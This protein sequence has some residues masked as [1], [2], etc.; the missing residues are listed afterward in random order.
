MKNQFI[1]STYIPKDKRKKILLLSDDLRMPSGVGTM[2]REI[3][4]NTAQHFNWV[5]IGGAI[6]HPEIGKV[7]DLSPDINN[8][9]GIQDSNVILYPSNGYGDANMVRNIMAFHKIDAILHYTDPRFWIWLYQIEHEIRQQIPILFYHVWDDLPYP[10]Y[11]QWFYESCDWISCISKQTHNIVK[12]VWKKNP[13]KDWQTAYIPHGINPDVF[14]PIEP[15][16]HTEQTKK[17]GEFKSSFF[18]MFPEEPE[19]IVLYNSRNIRRKLA[20]NVLLAFD[21]FCKKLPQEKADKCVLIMHTQPVDENGTD[22]PACVQSLIPNRKV[23]FSAGRIAPEDMNLLYNMSDVTINMSNAE[24]FGL[25]TAESVMAGTPMIATVTGGL[26][27]QMRFEDE[28]GNI[29]EFNS[30]FGSNHT[31]K[32]KKC[33]EWAFPLFPSV[34]SLT[35][36]PMTPYIFEDFAKFE[37]AADRILEVYN[38]PREERRRRGKSGRTWM[39]TEE[40]GMSAYEMANRFI[41]GINTTFQ[42]WTPRKSF[43]IFKI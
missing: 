1:E 3:V 31:G 22:L 26:Q 17:M 8:Y 11:N 37:D 34:R 13:P 6:N 16:I 2:S 40:S 39:L 7:F 15:E 33:G 5:Q 42:N 12:N 14:F 19:F 28:N 35:G 36:S 21:E 27:D 24:G 43:D 18:K 29:P 4:L 32:Y 41:K 38:M 9:L 20:T 30:E 25:G 10:Q 23:L